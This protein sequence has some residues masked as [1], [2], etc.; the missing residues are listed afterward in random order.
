MWTNFEK[1]IFWGI[2]FYAQIGFLKFYVIN[3]QD[4]L[5]FQSYYS[6]L[7]TY[8]QLL[9]NAYHIGGAILCQKKVSHWTVPIFFFIFLKAQECLKWINQ[10]ISNVSGQMF[11]LDRFFDGTFFTYGIEVMSFAGMFYFIKKCGLMS[12]VNNIE[13]WYIRF[14][15]WY[16]FYNS[17]KYYFS[18]LS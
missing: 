5:L 7:S 11:L 4:N 17:A 1:N 13:F 10:I 14:L 6:N 8:Y 3:S 16:N 12:I 2:G 9:E 15:V 18:N